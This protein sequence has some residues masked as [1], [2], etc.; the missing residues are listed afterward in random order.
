MPIR[1]FT[2]P[3][4]KVILQM[5]VD[6]IKDLSENLYMFGLINL[7]KKQ[8]LD[9]PENSKIKIVSISDSFE[10]FDKHKKEICKS[11]DDALK[12][13]NI[14]IVFC[15]YGQ[16][17]SVGSVLWY[18]MKKYDEKLENI[19]YTGEE[20]DWNQPI[21]SMIQIVHSDLPKRRRR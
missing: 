7:T 19:K 18:I 13:T 11:I 6:S 14:L 2:L 1:K 15:Q 12:E 10:D 8:L 9:F 3:N 16:S 20:I 4:S 17:R 5:N 21:P